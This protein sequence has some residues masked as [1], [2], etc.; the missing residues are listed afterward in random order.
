MSADYMFI[1]KSSED[2]S[3]SDGGLQRFGKIE[4]NPA[5]C[6]LN[7]GQVSLLVI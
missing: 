4:L 2:G 3:F 6:V 1:M 7:Y 5:A